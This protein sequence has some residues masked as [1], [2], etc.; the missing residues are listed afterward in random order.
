MSYLQTGTIIKI[1][2]LLCYGAWVL[3][4]IT[5]RNRTSLFD[6]WIE[7]WNFELWFGKLGT[8]CRLP[9]LDWKIVCTE[10]C[11]IVYSDSDCWQSELK[12]TIMVVYG[13]A[14]ITII[15]I[16]MVMVI[17]IVTIIM[18]MVIINIGYF[19][20]VLNGYMCKNGN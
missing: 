5:I 1:P 6:K 16:L 10:L 17:T 11:Y 20:Y 13:Y 2:S 3:P 18:V 4:K 12:I 14:Y 9:I 7:D 19:W 8:I 15:K